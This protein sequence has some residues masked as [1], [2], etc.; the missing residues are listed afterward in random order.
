MND[1]EQ[2]LGYSFIDKTLLDTALTH[3]SLSN[4]I[5][6]DNYERLEFLGDAIIELVVS[7]EIYKY[8][9]L[10]SGLLTRLRAS[11][12]STDNL[13]EIST[14][15]GLDKNLKKSKSLTTLSEKTK[16][17]IVESVV[18]AMYLDGGMSQAKKF[19]QKF[20][21]VDEENIKCHMQNCIDYKSRL[22]EEMQKAKKSFRYETI[23]ESGLAHDKTFEVQ[24]IVDEKVVSIASGK[25]LH[26]AQL[27]CAKKFFEK[28]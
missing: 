28:K 9:Y 8:K 4:E 26:M 3:I 19:V 13:S 20:I 15:L 18:G 25:S 24:L 23:S 17:D 1:V 16:A 11:L 6:C 5:G 12:V 27:E 22:Q 21:I 2:I 10:D 14:S 7:E